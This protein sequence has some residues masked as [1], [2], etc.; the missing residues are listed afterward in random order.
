MKLNS[1]I[2][3]F[4]RNNNTYSYVWSTTMMMITHRSSCFIVQG[5]W[6]RMGVSVG[7]L[8][9]HVA[10][11]LFRANYSSEKVIR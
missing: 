6:W 9:M 5:V 8:W 2:T 10:L 11:L 4:N 3:L 7:E 1:Y